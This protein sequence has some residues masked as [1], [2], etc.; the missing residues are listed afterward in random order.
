PSGVRDALKNSYVVAVSPIIGHKP[1]SGPAGKFMQAL[2]HEVSSFGVAAMYQ[3][4][5]DKF[6]ID[7][8]DHNQQKKIEKLISEVVVTNTNMKN[9]EDKMMLARNILGGN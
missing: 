8:Q 4:F 7:H 2:N 1:V 6:Y 3:D 5:L 9:I